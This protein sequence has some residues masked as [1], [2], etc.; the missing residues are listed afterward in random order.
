[1]HVGQIILIEAT[2]PEE[3]FGLVASNLSDGEPRWS[4]WH[5]ADNASTMNF[6]GRWTGEFFGKTDENGEVIDSD[7]APNHLCYSDDPALAES[8]ITR[9]LEN[10]M[11]DIR[12]YQAKAIDLA[13]YKYDPYATRFNMDLW[14]TKKLAQILD[15][16]WT[17]DSGV[18]DLFSWS[19][20]LLDFTKR[21]ATNPTQQY[22]IPVDFHF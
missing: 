10:R 22:L 3:A 9:A 15:D 14:A 17:P 13:S 5:N 7:T 1:M 19:A 12:Q 16:E 4:D 8:V 18:Y 20:S 2:S 6:A 21:V 11:D